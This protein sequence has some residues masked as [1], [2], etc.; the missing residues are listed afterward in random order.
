LTEFLKL[1][2]KRD[3]K[4]VKMRFFG[5]EVS[6]IEPEELHRERRLRS[7]QKYLS[8]RWNLFF[9]ISRSIKRKTH[10]FRP[11]SFDEDEVP[12]AAGSKR[13]LSYD[14]EKTPVRSDPGRNLSC[15]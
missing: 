15:V 1:L 14:D 11:R 2:R 8:S 9:T 13:N 3:Q 4:R 6:K 5:I 10:F 12:A 7:V